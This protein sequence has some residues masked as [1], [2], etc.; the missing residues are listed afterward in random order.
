MPASAR[1]YMPVVPRP[2]FISA[3]ELQ[4]KAKPGTHGSA[5][6]GVTETRLKI[7]WKDNFRS[8]WAPDGRDSFRFTGGELGLEFSIKVWLPRQYQPGKNEKDTLMYALAMGHELEHVQDDIEIYTTEL[9][10]SNLIAK[11]VILRTFCVDGGAGTGAPRPISRHDLEDLF[12]RRDHNAAQGQDG[13]MSKFEQQIFGVW[14]EA[15]KK[16]S[17]KVDEFG[18]LL[19]YTSNVGRVVE[20]DIKNI[21]WPL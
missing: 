10:N 9:T 4:R 11:C 19:L 13:A 6:M 1:V 16:R 20:N 5:T 21:S 18:A 14:L 17:Q 8:M 15:S 2:V 3:T 12:I 7:K